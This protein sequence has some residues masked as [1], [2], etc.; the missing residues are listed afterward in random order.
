VHCGAITP[1]ILYRFSPNFARGS[2]MWLLCRLLFV[3]Q[4]GNSLRILDVADSDLGSF[5]ALVTAFFN[6]SAPNPITQIKFRNADFVFNG[7]LNRK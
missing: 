2:E 5:Q 6:R 1:T 4:T 7:E 3:Q